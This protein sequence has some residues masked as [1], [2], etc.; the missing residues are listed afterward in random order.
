MDPEQIS[1][2]TSRNGLSH[3]G[4]RGCLAGLKDGAVHVTVWG[5]AGILHAVQEVPRFV[6]AALL[7]ARLKRVGKGGRIRLQPQLRH[8]LEEP[9]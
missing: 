6:I 7:A 3:L 8:L 4:R 9:A 2:T 1:F 5:E